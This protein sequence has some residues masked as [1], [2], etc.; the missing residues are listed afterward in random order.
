M[1]ESDICLFMSHVYG[2][3]VVLAVI[4]SCLVWLVADNKK[5]VDVIYDDVS[6]I[7]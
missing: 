7:R 5:A 4:Y 2:H 6:V 3:V 1:L